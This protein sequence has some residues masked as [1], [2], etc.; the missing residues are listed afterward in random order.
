MFH[1]AIITNIIHAAKHI[2]ELSIHPHQL[3]FIA[4]FS[5]L[6]KFFNKNNN[7]SISF[8]DYPSNN[9]WPLY[10]LVDKEPKLHRM[11]PILLSKILQEFSKKEECNN[12]VKKWQSN[13][14]ASNYKGRQFLDLNDDDNQFIHLT[15]FKDR[16]WLKYLVLS[17]LLCAYITRLITNHALIGKYRL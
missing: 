10:L 2:F 17:N 16:A 12:I 13:F 7:N 3:Y 14:Q 4:I 11:I 9:K 5:N 8:W 15:Y 1:I 6:R